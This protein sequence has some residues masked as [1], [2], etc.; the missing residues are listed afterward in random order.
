MNRTKIGKIKANHPE[1]FAP[2]NKA[3]AEIGAKFGGWGKRRKIA[4][5]KIKNK[6]TKNSKIFPVFEIFFS[7]NLY[8]LLKEARAMPERIN[9]LFNN[10]T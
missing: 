9:K 4:P 7:I 6:A 2:P 3:M 5:R 1:K 10:Y 8:Y